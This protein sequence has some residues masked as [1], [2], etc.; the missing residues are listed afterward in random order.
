MKEFL[1]HHQIAFQ[2]HLVDRDPAAL[3][4]LVEKTG[5]R[6]TPVLL[7]GEEAVVG[8]DRKKISSLLGIG[9]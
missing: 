1:S 2:E 8:F 6:A 7:V 9:A 3:K 4:T 5:R